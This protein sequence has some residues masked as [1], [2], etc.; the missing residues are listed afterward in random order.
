M[1]DKKAI[2]LLKKYYLSYRPDGQPSEAEKESAI[3]SGILVP[4]SSM[5]HDEIV[6]DGEIL[7]ISSVSGK[8][9]RYFDGEE[10]FYDSFKEALK[11]IIDHIKEVDEDYL[12]ED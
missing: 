2:A 1:M 9:V 5:T 11:S 4:D 12:L 6:G 8:F 3:K 10:T 7:C